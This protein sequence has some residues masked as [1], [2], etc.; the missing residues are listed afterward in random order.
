MISGYVFLLVG[1]SAWIRLPSVCLF[2]YGNKATVIYLIFNVLSAEDFNL[3]IPELWP[4][5][6]SLDPWPS[7]FM[8]GCF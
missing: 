2:A 4:T 1:E 8:K 6:S 7:S 5:T 3:I